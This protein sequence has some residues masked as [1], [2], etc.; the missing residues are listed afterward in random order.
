LNLSKEYS[1]Y[2]DWYDNGPGSESFKRSLN[3]ASERV[4][5]WPKW[6]QEAAAASLGYSWKDHEPCD[7]KGCLHH[8]KHPCEGCSRIGGVTKKEHLP[9]ELFE[10]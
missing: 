7:H 1:D 10:I 9:E 6:K 2:W 3:R 4:A 8:V 5:R